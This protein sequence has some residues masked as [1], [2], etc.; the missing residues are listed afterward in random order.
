VCAVC[1]SPKGSGEPRQI[2][3][4]FVETERTTQERARTIADGLNTI[5]ATAPATSL[6]KAGRKIK[7]I[8]RHV[9]EEIAVRR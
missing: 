3:V 4:T 6:E 8:A 9:D 2:F 7:E 1:R 5:D